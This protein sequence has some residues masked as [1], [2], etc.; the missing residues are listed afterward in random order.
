MTGVQTCAL[1]IWTC[2]FITFNSEISMRNLTCVSRISFYHYS[3]AAPQ[4]QFKSKK[5]LD[6]KRWRIE[7]AL[8]VYRLPVI[9]PPMTDVQREF[10]ELSEQ[11]DFSQ[12]YKNDFELLMEKDAR[13]MEKRKKFEAEGKD[14][15]E[16]DEQLGV[17][18]FQHLDEW[19]QRAERLAG[20]YNFDDPQKS[21]DSGPEYSLS[22]D[23]DKKLVLAVRKR[24]A[25]SPSADYISP[26]TIPTAVNG[27]GETLKQTVER[28][29]KLVNSKTKHPNEPKPYGF[30]IMGNAPI[31][32]LM[33]KYPKPMKERLQLD[34]AI[35]IF[36]FLIPRLYN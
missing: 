15:S 30:R 12:S 4:Q 18:S 14:L 32:H 34:G 33:Q 16:L 2:Y 11:L 25:D 21:I 27:D 17:T 6:P 8:M 1:P 28:C 36:N 26:W 31:G 24:F 29:L 22:R 23:L 5:V 3:T 10:I 13:L 35:V 20:T 7:V 19:K 9:A